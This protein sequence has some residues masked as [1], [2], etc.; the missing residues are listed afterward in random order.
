MIVSSLAPNNRRIIFPNPN[1]IP[2]RM[3]DKTISIHM[4]LPIAFSACSVSPFPI[5][6]D[7]FGAP[8]ILTSAAKAEIARIT[9]AVTPTPAKADF[10]TSGICPINILSTIL[11]KIL[12]SCA[13][14]A[15]QASRKKAFE[16]GIS[17]NKLFSFIFS[18]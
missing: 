9:G 10:P 5:K 12:M 2:V 17:A 15:G 4:Q 1:M 13:A 3:T 14:T 7:A 11:Y 18:T 16:T 6:I 8:P